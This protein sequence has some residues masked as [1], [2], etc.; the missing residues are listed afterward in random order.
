MIT[1]PVAVP[2]NL[3]KWQIS[4]F[5]FSYRT[6]Y[7]NEKLFYETLVL[8]CDRNDHRSIVKDVDWNLKIPYKMVDGIHSI[9]DKSDTHS[10]F[11]A[12]NLF[13]ALK[14]ILNNFYHQQIICL[15]DSDVIPLKPYN[16][17]L[18][19]ED[20]VV[21]CNFY[22]DWHMFCSTPEKRNFNVVEPYLKHH[23]YNYMDGGFVPILIR[24]STLKKIIDDV[25]DLSLEIAK[26]YLDSPFGWWMQMW[27]FQIVCHNHRIKCIGQDNTYFPHINELKDEHYFAHYSCDPKFEKASFPNHNIKEFP[28]NKFYDTIRQWYFR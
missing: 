28:H 7:G 8:I 13:F 15:I 16:G 1:I 9:L 17:I 24:I 10:Y 14:S 19:D 25:I 12:G 22:E 5:D 27:A 3:F 20:T 4:L 11:S 18:P 21:T 23:D 6:I 26:K 2:N